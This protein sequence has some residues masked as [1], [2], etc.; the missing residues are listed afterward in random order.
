MT[1]TQ[2]KTEKDIINQDKEQ[3]QPTD[4]QSPK[5]GT[6]TSSPKLEHRPPNDKVFATLWFMKKEAYAE[7]T[8]VAVGKRLR[9]LERSCNLADSEHVKGYVASKACGMARASSYVLT[10]ESNQYSTIPELPSI[11]VLPWFAIATLLT[12]IAYRRKWTR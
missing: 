12:R 9:H 5:A 2:G 11:L 1:E 10:A 6:A 4:L 8:I 7:S 3:T